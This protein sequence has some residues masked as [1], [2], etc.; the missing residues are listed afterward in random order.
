MGKYDGELS[1]YYTVGSKETGMPINYSFDQEQ[2]LILTNVTG[3]LSIA[4]TEDYFER[5]HQDKECPER[6]IEVVDFSNVTDFAIQYGEMKRITETYQHA[7]LTKGILATIFNCSSNLSYGIARMLQ[8]LHEIGESAFQAAHELG[9]LR[10]QMRRIR[11][12]PEE[13]KSIAMEALERQDKDA[14]LELIEDQALRHAKDKDA[15][16]KRATKAEQKVEVHERLIQDKDAKIN[17]LDKQL[18]QRELAP[19]SWPDVVGEISIAERT[20]AQD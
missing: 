3:K 11:Q 10:A 2:G 4:I 5:L 19:P 18:K 12:L 9:L 7:K 17:Q 15:L 20:V 14:V 13:T 1:T 8:T 16:E 6:A